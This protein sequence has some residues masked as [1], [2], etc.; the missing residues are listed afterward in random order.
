MNQSNTNCTGT[1]AYG[2]L[3]TAPQNRTRKFHFLLNGKKYFSHPAGKH[4][5]APNNPIISGF[6]QILITCLPIKQVKSL[7]AFLTLKKAS[8]RLSLSIPA[9]ILLFAVSMTGSLLPQVKDTLSAAPQNDM[10]M[11]GEMKNDGGLWVRDFKNERGEI[12]NLTVFDIDESAL[13][14]VTKKPGKADV[15]DADV[16]SKFNLKGKPVIIY[17]YGVVTIKQLS[18]E[19]LIDHTVWPVEIKTANLMA[20]PGKEGWGI[21]E[22]NG[23]KELVVCYAKG[24]EKLLRAYK[25]GKDPS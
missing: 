15:N 10:K 25:A 2:L 22:L 24:S 17:K 3:E 21:I 6:M 1:V 8:R 23:K 14:E 7:F 13:K 11:S 18:M 19:S 5:P 4:S 12:S 16:I 9:L 20:Y